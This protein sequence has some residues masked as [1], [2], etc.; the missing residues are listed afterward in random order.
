MKI[1]MLYLR[2]LMLDF[3]AMEGQLLDMLGVV[4]CQRER[5]RALIDLN[6]SANSEGSDVPH[7]S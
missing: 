4:N 5:L 3:T 1:P 2:T 6:E 7:G